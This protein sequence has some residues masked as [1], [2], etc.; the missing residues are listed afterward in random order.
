L[1]SPTFQ[2]G[3]PWLIGW[4]KLDIQFE[5]QGVQIFSDRVDSEVSVT[6]ENLV[7]G[8]SADAKTT[9]DSALSAQV[10]RLKGFMECY[11]YFSTQACSSKR[12]FAARLG[13]DSVIQRA[14]ACSSSPVVMATAHPGS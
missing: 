5:A 11:E 8:R 2:F 12:C 13:S 14:H 7:H 6:T 9:G 10:G 4:H 1:R 3:T